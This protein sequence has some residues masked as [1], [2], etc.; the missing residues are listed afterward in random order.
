MA[1]AQKPSIP[2]LDEVLARA[3][4]HAQLSK[5]PDVV[6]DPRTAAFFLGVHCK[7]LERWRTERRPP[8][9][10]AMNAKDKSGVQVLYRVGEL[11]AF[12]QQSQTR[13][14]PKKAGDPEKTHK[15]VNGKRV[16]PSDM[17]WV[18]SATVEVETLEE[19]F[20]MTPDGLILAHGWEEATTTIAERL[21]SGSSRIAWMAWDK[22]LAAVWLDDRLRLA[23]LR[24]ADTVAPGLRAA[25]EEIRHTALS[26]M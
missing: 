14:E 26:R 1:A 15:V 9:P 18:A 5:A 20:F 7:K 19:P 11:L 13:P 17:P 6:L 22:A 24:H 16:K 12:I 2:D 25:A 23:W 10:V 3:Q 21:V 8:H 4:L